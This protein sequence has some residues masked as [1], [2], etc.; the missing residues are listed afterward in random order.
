MQKN[1]ACVVV[2]IY[3]EIS[4]KNEVLSIEQALKI[5]N[6]HH[7][8]FICPRSFDQSFISKFVDRDLILKVEIFENEYFTSVNSYNKL[9][10]SEKFYQRFSDYEFMLIYQLDAYVFD[11]QLEY[12][13]NRNFDFI[14]A[15]WFKKFDTTGKEKEFIA[16]AGN[17]GFSLRNI[18]KINDLMQKK[19][20]LGQ[21]ISLRN[22]L[23]KSRTK[24]NK[25]LIFTAKFFIN[26]FRKKNSL[27]ELCNFICNNAKAPNED[28][29]FAST[30]PKIFPDFKSAKAV[31]AIPFSFEAQAE[32]LYK[33][34]GN[35]LPFGCHA[36]EKYSPD[37]WKKFINF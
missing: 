22:I 9:L 18:Q 37:F 21:M 15:P 17:G 12:W 10:L 11:D 36:W 7:I 35:K 16:L 2:P 33:I 4:S 25:N 8:F 1:K 31:E 23:A 3:K 26:F 29:F 20:S 27:A 32:N 5:L 30:L 19:L 34:N 14:G 13:C 24:S 6:N 28:Y